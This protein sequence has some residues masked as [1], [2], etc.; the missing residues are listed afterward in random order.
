M[1]I[2]SPLLLL[3][4]LSACSSTQQTRVGGAVST[5]FSDLNLA[6]NVI[7]EPLLRAQKK[8][9]LAPLDQSCAA[10]AIEIQVFEDILGAD[11]DML[12]AA[13]TLNEKAE[14]AVGDAAIGAIQSAAEGVVPFRSWVRKLTGAEKYAKQAAAATAAGIARRSFL[15][16]IRLARDCV[17]MTQPKPDYPL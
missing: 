5:P 12:A 7:P 17:P 11:V 2:F 4:L 16:G 8:P 10:L 13:Q 1:R 9:Y 3:L 15:K 6:Q 14:E